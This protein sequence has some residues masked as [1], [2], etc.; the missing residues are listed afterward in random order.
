MT[1][2]EGI[3][4]LRVT[5]EAT[6]PISIGSMET[7]I[8]TVTDEIKL[9]EGKSKKRQV[10]VPA[11]IRGPDGL[12]A[13]PAA[14]L[15]GGLRDLAERYENKE[16]VKTYFGF[17]GPN[18]S[19]AASLISFGWGHAHDSKD[20]CYRGATPP[21]ED[22]IFLKRLRQPKPLVRDHVAIN[23]FGVVD[24]RGKFMRAAVPVGTRFSFE[25]SANGKE[26]GAV[27]D[28]LTALLHLMACRDLAL[29][30]GR[31]RGYGGA[32]LVRA[33][34]QWF[35]Y[36]ESGIHEL[37]SARLKPQSIPLSK[38]IDLPDAWH[39]GQLREFEIETEDFI[40]VG[41]RADGAKCFV[42]SEGGTRS[43]R[44]IKPWPAFV[45][46]GGGRDNTLT[47]LAEPAFRW[48]G[49][50]RVVT[51][52]SLPGSAVKGPLAHRTLYWWNK[53]SGRTINPD[54][55]R[56]FENLDKFSRRDAVLEAMFGAIKETAVMGGRR[57]ALDVEESSFDAGYIAKQDHVSIDRFTSGASD[58]DGALFSEELLFDASV[59]LAFRLRKPKDID[60]S[61]WHLAVQALDLAILDLAE[62]RLPLGGRGHGTMQLVENTTAPVFGSGREGLLHG[63]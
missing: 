18:H 48:S 17:A 21:P 40:R 54:E 60:E 13:V 59:K 56:S 37:F 62:G 47:L 8:E 35:A 11:L 46:D 5:L 34:H 44:D 14:S 45:D 12:P 51:R 6:S 10:T 1:S 52:F 31:S 3:H 2:T 49:E 33:S 30:W 32:R 24:G 29:G 39:E 22:D 26:S 4:L 27:K 42:E 61:D 50:D 25:F 53:L 43:A 63:G 55:T 19:G 38:V 41:G 7:E 58:R 36:N 57:S 20:N 9:S 16:F 28:A 15:R 23:Q